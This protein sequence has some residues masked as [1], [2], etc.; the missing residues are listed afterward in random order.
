M[1][2]SP[3]DINM[4]EKISDEN[5]KSTIYFEDIVFQQNE[6]IRLYR[7]GSGSPEGV[8][9]ANP[10]TA[11]LNS[12]GGAGTTLFVKESGTGDTGWIGK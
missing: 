6:N 11:Y 12:D 7:S 10:G 9:T 1:A 3:E 4:E 2:E 8:V 5:G